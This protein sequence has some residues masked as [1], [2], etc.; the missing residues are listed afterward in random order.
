MILR[1][2]ASSSSS[3]PHPVVNSSSCDEGITFSLHSRSP[4]WGLRSVS[5]IR[6]CT[7]YGS[8]HV[9]VGNAANYTSDDWK[10]DIHLAQ[11]AQIDA[12]ALN[13]AYKEANIE[14]S[15]PT[16]FS[17]AAGMG[18]KLFFSFD[19]AGN[20]AWPKDEVDSMLEKY[21]A[22]SAY[23]KYNGKYLVSTFE[24]PDSADDWIDLK[25]DRNVFFIPDWSSLGA[26]AALTRGG[27]VADGLF[28]WAAWPWG[29]QDMD[30]YTDASYLQYLNGKP[31]MMPIS[32]WFFTNL[33]GYNKNW[34]W[35]GDSL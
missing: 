34:L 2:P 18:F 33:P 7:L 10:T 32:P 13:I 29:P 12:F 6:V 16:A 3:T 17:A 30:T 35:R 1:R 24:G 21:T 9:Q 25:N 15:L 4:A 19:Y 5:K 23:F 14:S 27:G 26:K 20:G 28:S 11:Q 22:L 8:L 31:Y